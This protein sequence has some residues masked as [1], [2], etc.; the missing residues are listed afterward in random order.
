[1][2]RET[3]ITQTGLNAMD[4]YGPTGSLKYTQNGTWPDGTPR[5]VQ[6][7]SLSPEQQGIFNTNQGTQQNIANIGREQSARIGGLLGTPMK[8][9]NDAVES[10][11][12]ELGT[13]RL[14]PQFARNDEAMRTRLANSGIRAGSAAFDAEMHNADYAKNDALNSLLLAGR[15]QAN[16]E[17]LTE[18]NQPINEITALMS[19]S[20]VSNPTFGSTPQ[21]QVAGVD[22]AGMVNNNYNAQMQG[23]NAQMQNQNAMMGGMFGLGGSL[24]SAALRYGGGAALFSDRRLKSDIER[25][26]T[27]SHG[28]PLYEYTIF[29][30]RK[31]G[32]MADEVAEVMP[33]AV[34][35][36]PSGYQMVNYSMLGLA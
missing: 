8:L 10:R 29:G 6:T 15:G 2:N 36:H 3:A 13:K 7:V 4:Q 32:V 26:G 27:T 17:L 28:L 12:M 35:T 16:Q 24:G 18:R 11:L 21:T 19:G 30:E 34:M 25:I 22:Y 9:G 33:A 14:S 5:F 20:Q 23:Y 1:M 31:R